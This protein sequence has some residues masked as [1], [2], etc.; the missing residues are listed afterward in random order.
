M[1]IST[2]IRSSAA[3]LTA[4]SLLAIS[5]VALAHHDSP[6]STFKIK[7]LPDSVKFG[8]SPAEVE[9]LLGQ[10]VNKP[11]W[12]SGATTWTYRTD[13]SNQRFDVDFG[14]DGK[15]KSVGLYKTAE[16]GNT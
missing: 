13:A 12:F 10:P 8:M 2:I 16:T 9:H 6:A 4:L 1:K 14:T 15:V 5:P 7:Q 11:V 3:A